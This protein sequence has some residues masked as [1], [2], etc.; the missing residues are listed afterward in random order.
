VAVHPERDLDRVV[1]FSDAIVAIAMTLLVL[2]LTGIS[3]KD[4]SGLGQLLEHNATELSS[5]VVSFLVI[6]SFWLSHHRIF[7]RLE[8]IDGPLL[9][10]NLLWLLGIVFLPFPTS[11][12]QNDGE[13]SYTVFYMASLFGV[14]LLTRALGLYVERHPVLA[15][16][17]RDTSARAGT[18]RGWAAVA[19]FGVALLVSLVA[20]RLATWSLL[21][22]IPVSIASRRVVGDGVDA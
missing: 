21:L 18:A 12:V 9:R 1:A 7:D 19:V 20:P 17:P 8:A 10:L 4:Y 6:A 2:P 5:F 14:A 16:A 22:L 13:E 3:P 15:P 11:L